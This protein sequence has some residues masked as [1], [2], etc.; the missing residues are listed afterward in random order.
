M[1]YAVIAISLL[2]CN[3][4]FAQ[5]T[6]VKIW[7]GTDTATVTGG[8]L[9][10][11]ATLDTTGLATSAKQDTGNTSLASIDG[12]ITACNTGAVVIS[13]GSLTCNAG[14]NLNTSAL[15]TSAKQ[16]TIIG[17]LDGVE[18]LLT[19][20]DG[21]TGNI[22]TSTASIDGKI[23]ACD[24]DDV[25]V[26]SSALPTGAATEATLST[27]NGKVTACNTGAVTVSTF[28]DNEPIN[29]AQINGTTVSMGNGASGTGVQRVTIASDST[30]VLQCNAGT[31][32]NTS[33]LATEATLSTL[34]GK[35][36][37]CNTG[38]VTISAALPAG[39]N[40]IGKL[41][42]NSGVDIGDVDVTSIAAGN[43]NIGD[44]DVASIAA[45]NNNI[46]DVD[47]IQSGTWTVQPG[48]TAN[49]TAW[50]VSPRPSTS[51]GLTIA[52]FIDLDESDQQIKGTAGQL[53]G[54]FIY[55]NAASTRYVKL[56]NATAASVTVG[57]TTPAMTIAIPAG[58]AA[59][60]EFSMGIAFSTA[61]TAACLTGVADSDTG[62][63][64]ANDCVT[65]FLYN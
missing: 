34:N 56:Y 8:A 63:P 45:G 3:C 41:A 15:A 14:T 32:L 5:S 23:A 16:D 11:N 65:N 7:D 35:V 55:N 31:N 54:Y 48:N 6:S 62:A 36:T 58:S 61:I 37:A 49:T 17:H 33:A 9:D 1:R 38:A 51:G 39:T 44:V 47:A 13:S 20:I 46:G 22:A 64:A 27:L 19:T 40:A 30:G 2:L 29:V 60:V 57:S 26:S 59:N 53:Y 18:A 10:V 43:N 24:T 4:A 52:R 21:D 28:P 25:T 50:L 12:K 42:A